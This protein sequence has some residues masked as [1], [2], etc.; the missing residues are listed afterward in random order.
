MRD[1]KCFTMLKMSVSAGET[2]LFLLENSPLARAVCIGYPV[3]AR[4]VPVWKV[5]EQGGHAK[6]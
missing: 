6:S 3:I 2:S 1:P 5:G 4:D